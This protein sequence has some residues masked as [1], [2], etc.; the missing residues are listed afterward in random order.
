MRPNFYIPNSLSLI[1][2]SFNSF[3]GCDRMRGRRYLDVFEHLSIPFWD[4]TWFIIWLLT[5]TLGLS[6]PFW[7]ATRN[8]DPPLRG[9]R[10][11]TFNSFL[12]CDASFFIVTL[13]DT[14]TFQFLSGMRHNS[15]IDQKLWETPQ[16]SIPFWDATV[17]GSVEIIES[18]YP[19]NSFL[20]CD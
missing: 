19:F 18:L 2:I 14:S 11:K 16:L 10:Y 15:L 3:L 1:F 13:D 9:R 8:R 17:I 5:Y 4:A 7:D 12:G 20:G 6:I